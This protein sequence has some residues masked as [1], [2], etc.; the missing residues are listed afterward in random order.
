[1]KS[2]KFPKN[3]EQRAQLEK[4]DY[5]Y[6]TNNRVFPNFLKVFKKDLNVQHL[7]ERF[8]LD[9]ITRIV[10]I[11]YYQKNK[12]SFL[13]P[14]LIE[15]QFQEA[16][17]CCFYYL[18]SESFDKLPTYQTF[19]IS[20][21]N[22]QNLKHF[23]KN[24]LKQHFTEYLP[25]LNCVFVFQE[26]KFFCKY[27]L[28]FNVLVIW[29]KKKLK[30]INPNLEKEDLICFKVNNLDLP[31]EHFVYFFGKNPLNYEE[32]IYFAN[33][34]KKEKLKIE[35]NKN[36]FMLETI[37][38]KKLKNPTEQ[39]IQDNLSNNQYKNDPD[40]TNENNN[41]RE[42]RN[43]NDT[44]EEQEEEK[45]IEKDIKQI[46]ESENKL[47]TELENSTKKIQK[48]D[49]AINTRHEI[50]R[51]L[52]NQLEQKNRNEGKSNPKAKK[53]KKKI[54]SLS[55]ERNNSSK[56]SN[57][58][59]DSNNS[60]NH[61]G[62][63]KNEPDS[64]VL[65]KKKEK[66]EIKEGIIVLISNSKPNNTPHR[67]LMKVIGTIIKTK[68]QDHQN[69][70]KY[71]FSFLKYSNKANQ[72]SKRRSPMKFMND[73]NKIN[74]YLSK[75]E[76]KH[77]I[78]FKKSL[79]LINNQ[80]LDDY[81]Q[82]YL[83]HFDFN[84]KIK[85]NFKQNRNQIQ[86]LKK[87]KINYIYSYFHKQNKEYKKKIQN[88]GC[89]S[90]FFKKIDK[91]KLKNTLNK[92]I[93][94]YQD[95]NENRTSK[96]PSLKTKNQKAEKSSTHKT[97]S[98]RKIIKSNPGSDSGLDTSTDSDN[99]SDENTNNNEN[100]NS[101]SGYGTSS[102]SKS[103]DE[104]INPNFIEHTS[105][106]KNKQQSQSDS[107]SDT[108]SNNHSTTDSDNNTNRKSNSDTNSNSDSDSSS[109]SSS[110]SSSGS[111]S[112]SDSDS[113]SDSDSETKTE[114]ENHTESS[115]EDRSTR[116]QTVSHSKIKS[117]QRKNIKTKTGQNKKDKNIDY[118]R[119][120]VTTFKGDVY[121]IKRAKERIQLEVKKTHKSNNY[122]LINNSNKKFIAKFFPEY[123]DGDN[124]DDYYKLESNLRTILSNN[125]ITKEYTQKLLH[126]LNKKLKRKKRLS[127]ISLHLAKFKEPVFQKYGKMCVVQEKI[128]KQN[129]NITKI[130][131]SFKV[132]KEADDLNLFFSTFSHFSYEKSKHDF[133]IVNFVANKYHI[134]DQKIISK[135]EQKFKN[136]IKAFKKYHKCNH[137][138]KKLKLIRFH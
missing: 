103:N 137:Y 11:N 76:K 49:Q 107:D 54:S 27:N 44:K 59:P 82:T 135:N 122:E 51:Q 29:L 90:A 42:A 48:R 136:K 15:H 63:D 120:T 3:K 104:D 66:K 123:K 124:K 115:D 19:Q 133:I 28:T 58:K 80:N 64:S 52:R 128:E 92:F 91:E 61:A 101:S 35:K 4:Q 102:S 23:N 25:T 1:M 74:W 79:K 81:H 75:S 14:P 125:S 36:S 121:N 114:S 53:R 77:G 50:I 18:N 100:T 21:I 129:H 5:I 41:E 106:K 116:N 86:E 117:K 118:K 39:N 7:K 130:Y 84:R 37:Y 2:N 33:E 108:N 40:N 30:K 113:D 99:N 85:L 38:T 55:K 83:L 8:R 138:C 112:G 57:C 119:Y 43:K 17:K 6:L 111:S 12:L 131:N 60:S 56:Q 46:K 45:E 34:F 22:S 89:S 73:S 88:N 94:K 126:V 68:L 24:K 70:H 20:T 78:S 132:G 109:S 13:E 72:S 16:T 97:P 127:V 134:W 98:K 69:H 93:T 71:Y 47:R 87:K 67:K 10:K 9:H 65:K 62:K 95:K 96:T 32:E 31:L 26:E 110:D 105:K